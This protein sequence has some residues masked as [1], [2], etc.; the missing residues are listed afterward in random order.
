MG[1]RSATLQPHRTI[2]SARR[3]PGRGGICGGSGRVPSLLARCQVDR[4]RSPDG[5]GQRRNRDPRDR[6]FLA[7]AETVVTLSAASVTFSS[8]LVSPL[9][10]AMRTVYS[11]GG[12]SRNWYGLSNSS[13]CPMNLPFTNTPSNLLSLWVFNLA[14]GGFAMGSAASVLSS[15]SVLP[16]SIWIVLLY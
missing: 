1:T 5:L 7:P 3:L 4:R 2:P 9:G 8:C 14:K 10:A 15:F 11:P 13:T 6:Y 16:A 12:S